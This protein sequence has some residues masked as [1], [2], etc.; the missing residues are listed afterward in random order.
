[1]DEQ[2]QEQRELTLEEKLE[3]MTQ[4]AQ[5][6]AQE[7]DAMRRIILRMTAEKYLGDK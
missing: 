6:Q 1:M 4:L 7:I 5:S 3:Q 2:K